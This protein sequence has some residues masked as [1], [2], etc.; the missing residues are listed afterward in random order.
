MDDVSRDKYA[1]KYFL[2]ICF[3]STRPYVVQHIAETPCMQ[4]NLIFL[5]LFFVSNLGCY[6]WTTFLGINMHTNFSSVFVSIAP[7]S[8]LCS[9][10]QKHPVYTH[11][12]CKNNGREPGNF[13]SS[14]IK[15]DT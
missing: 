6:S 5:A 9:I 13:Y 7:V 4:M 3:Y 10:L 14:T 15:I 1:Y 11:I 2:G 8:M 12:C